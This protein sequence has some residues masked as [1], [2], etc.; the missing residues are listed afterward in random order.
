MG[1]VVPG[2]GGPEAAGTEPGGPAPGG[3]TFTL[4]GDGAAPGFSPGRILC[5]S[6][7]RFLFGNQWSWTPSGG[8][9]ER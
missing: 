1:A 4:F 8:G 2:G 6:I 3:G 5:P 9:I 7:C